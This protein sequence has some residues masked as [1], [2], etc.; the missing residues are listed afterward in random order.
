MS[1][2]NHHVL[3]GKVDITSN[4][5]VGSSHLFVDTENNRVGLVTA[6]PQAGLHVNSNAYVNTDLRVGPA[7]PNQVVINATAGRIKATLF[8][9]D[10]SLLQNTPPGAPGAAATIAV[11]TTTTGAAGSSASVTNSGTTSAAVFNFVIPRGDQGIPGNDGAD[12]ADGAPGADGA[13]GADGAPGA[14]GTNYFT[15]SGLN[16]YRS[17]GNVGIGTSSPGRLLEVYTGNGTVPGFRLRRGAGAAYTDLHHAAVNVP[18]T[19]D[20]EG[21]AVITS[22]G[23]QTTQEVMRICGNGNV[24]I[25]Q[26]SPYA[27]LDVNGF[28]KGGPGVTSR[29]PLHISDNT[30]DSSNGVGNGKAR[31]M[32]VHTPQDQY[33]GNEYGLEIG[34]SGTGNSLLQSIG[35]THSTGTTAAQYN[36][37]LQPFGGRVGV[38]TSVPGAILDV[39]GSDAASPIK[40]SASTASTGTYN[41]VL[42]GPRPGTTGGGATHFIN[43]STRSDDGGASVY[44]IRNDSGPLRLGHP[45]HNNVIDGPRLDV[46]GIIK[47]TG[48]NWALTNGGVSESLQ[49]RG[50]YVG[51]YAYLNRTLS[52]PTN[53]TLTH[54]YQGGHYTRSRITVGTTG[55]YAMYINGFRQNGTSGTKELFLYKNGAYVSV[56]AYSGPESGNTGYSTVGSAYTIMDLNANDYVEVKIQQGTYHGNDSIY[57]AGH[58]IA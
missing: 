6:N 33:H 20:L 35:Y 13:D 7:G 52:T 3:T 30:L 42:N 12:G 58:L 2:T 34:V 19:G 14:D 51:D 29:A 46:N 9:G 25:N 21:L 50:A 36:L 40:K 4:L 56:R 57:F 41:F 18:N 10:G 31:F 49:Y 26:T 43:G 16:I 11:G 1:D 8:E 38:G 55:K 37:S 23:N 48:A 54:E 47:Q 15:L 39:E 44:T 28:V 5:L 24:G 32:M 22:D 17:T 45:S 53:V 27:K